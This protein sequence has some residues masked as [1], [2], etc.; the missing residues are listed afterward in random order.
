ML[1]EGFTIKQAKQEKPDLAHSSQD[2]SGVWSAGRNQSYSTHSLSQNYLYLLLFFLLVFSQLFH[3]S[4][5]Q[6]SKSKEEY[7][8]PEEVHA[9]GT[10]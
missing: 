9:Q 6:L 3:F 1:I 2:C 10:L 4:T 8:A 7:T 5:I